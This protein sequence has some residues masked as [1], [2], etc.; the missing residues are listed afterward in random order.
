MNEFMLVPEDYFLVTFYK[1]VPKVIKA[2]KEKKHLFNR[3][4]VEDA[5][6][7]DIGSEIEKNLIALGEIIAKWAKILEN[8]LLYAPETD[9]VMEAIQDTFDLAEQFAEVPF[10]TETSPRQIYDLDLLE[11]NYRKLSAIHAMLSIATTDANRD[12][13]PMNIFKKTHHMLSSRYQ[14]VLDALAVAFGIRA[15]PTAVGAI[16]FVLHDKQMFFTEEEMEEIRKEE[17]AKEIAEAKAKELDELRRQVK[18]NADLILK[19]YNTHKQ[20]GNLKKFELTEAA[21]NVLKEQNSPEECEQV[22]AL[23]CLLMAMGDTVRYMPGEEGEPFERIM[24]SFMELENDVLSYNQM[25]QVYL[26]N[27][28]LTH[29]KVVT[30]LP[31]FGRASGK[32]VAQYVDTKEYLDEPNPELDKGMRTIHLF[33]A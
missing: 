6:I 14:Y 21:I 20:M 13:Y 22:N 27:H 2:L 17:E 8:P 33:C 28:G 18:C 12:Q 26:G 7:G 19:A 16:K 24:G 3:L 5:M 10:G 9:K 4:T 32:I 31:M 23:Y 30:A 25:F 15:E 1:D 29:S 11:S